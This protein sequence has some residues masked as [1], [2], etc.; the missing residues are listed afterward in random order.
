MLGLR[1]RR[2]MCACGLFPSFSGRQQLQSTRDGLQCLPLRTLPPLPRND[3]GEAG[4]G[5]GR[6]RPS[7]P[8]GRWRGRARG[9]GLPC[10]G[11]SDQRCS[12]RPACNGWHMHSGPLSL[13]SSSAAGRLGLAG[14]NTGSRATMAGAVHALAGQPDLHPQRKHTLHPCCQLT[15]SLVEVGVEVGESN[16]PRSLRNS[17]R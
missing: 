6:G 11:P 10:L 2:A 16:P 17:P 15:F 13:C 9:G 1:N 7:S 3:S 5:R 8:Q 12:N 4:L 14:C